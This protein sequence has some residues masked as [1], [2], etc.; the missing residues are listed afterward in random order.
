[1]LDS[2]YR[3]YLKVVWWIFVGIQPEA[4]KR[5]SKALHDVLFTKIAFAYALPK[6][7]VG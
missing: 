2:L 5:G 4:E 3:S 7:P 1:M 6:T